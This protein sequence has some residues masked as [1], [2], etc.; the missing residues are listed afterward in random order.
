MAVVVDPSGTGSCSGN[1]NQPGAC[2]VQ[3]T[4]HLRFD[5]RP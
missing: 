1:V 3:L 5:A 4:G 2:T